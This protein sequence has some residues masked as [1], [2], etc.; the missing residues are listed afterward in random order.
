MGIVWTD[1]DNTQLALS[2]EDADACDD[3]WY[4]TE[5]R[6]HLG[7]LHSFTITFNFITY[8]LHL[9]QARCRIAGCWRHFTDTH[10]GNSGQDCQDT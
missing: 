8:F 10:H 2:F 4:G 1:V 7:P 9:Q 3:I 5:A 6:R